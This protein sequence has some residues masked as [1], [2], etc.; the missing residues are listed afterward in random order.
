MRLVWWLIWILGFVL[1]WA[2][3]GTLAANY[4]WESTIKL[5]SRLRAAW[6]AFSK[7]AAVFKSSAFAF[8]LKAEL[9]EITVT[10][11]ALYASSSWTMTDSMEKALRTTQ[12][13]ML[14]TMLCKRRRPDEDWVAFVKRTTCHAEG[15]MR[16]AG[17]NTW[18]EQ[19]RR[20]KWPFAART[21]RTEDDRWSKRLLSWRPFFNCLPRRNVGQ[22]R[23]RWEDSI[24]EVAGGNWSNSAVDKV[25]WRALEPAFVERLVLWG[26]A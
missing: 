8:P 7:Y 2:S 10:L 24:A 17:H 15:L 1:F 12:R 3:N 9:F 4:V 23:R 14:R 13:R 19:Y 18:V 21:V 25:L 22:P 16:E 26:S 11:V 20:K 6:A 5:R